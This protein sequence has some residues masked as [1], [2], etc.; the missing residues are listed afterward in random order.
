MFFTTSSKY[1]ICFCNFKLSQIDKAWAQNLK[2]MV[3]N[4]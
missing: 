4:D 2:M 1:L 3:N